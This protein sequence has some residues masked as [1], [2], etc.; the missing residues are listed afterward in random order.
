MN[1]NL[2]LDESVFKVSVVKLKFRDFPLKMFKKKI[3]IHK[4][5]QHIYKYSEVMNLRR[6]PDLQQTVNIICFLYKSLSNDV[7]NPDLY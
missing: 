1:C 2:I 6:P 5:N 4:N 7:R 3:F